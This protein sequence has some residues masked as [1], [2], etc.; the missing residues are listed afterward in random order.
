MNNWRAVGH[1]ARGEQHL[2]YIGISAEQV[3]KNYSGPFYEVLTVEEQSAIRRVTLEKWNGKP[4]S[5]KW[6]INDN[7]RVPRVH[8]A[9][10]K[11]EK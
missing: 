6:T 8:K 1:T 11:T 7:L 4:D 3:K 9:T 2:L 10:E 5:G